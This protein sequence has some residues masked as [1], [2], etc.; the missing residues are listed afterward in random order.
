MSRIPVSWRVQ[1]FGLDASALRAT[2]RNPSQ[3]LPEAHRLKQVSR[4]TG[5]FQGT[6]MRSVGEGIGVT[7]N[8]VHGRRGRGVHRVNPDLSDH[9]LIR[10]KPLGEYGVLTLLRQCSA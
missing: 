9:E 2:R 7:Q 3:L 6:N 4:L 1:A 10:V 8:L 5:S